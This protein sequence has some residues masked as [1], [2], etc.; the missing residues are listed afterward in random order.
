MQTLILAQ[1]QPNPTANSNQTT[2]P[3]LGYFTLA[4][5]A[6]AGFFAVLKSVLTSK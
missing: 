6:M 2:I 4:L 5:L 3:D 1:S